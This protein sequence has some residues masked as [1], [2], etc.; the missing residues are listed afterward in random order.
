MK[1][2]LLLFLFLG[3]LFS[4]QS[5]NACCGDNGK[6]DL[7]EFLSTDLVAEVEV[8]SFTVDKEQQKF[9]SKTKIITNYKST[10][11]FS[12]EIIIVSKNNYLGVPL[13]P[14]K[15]FVWLNFDQQEGAYRLNQCNRILPSAYLLETTENDPHFLKYQKDRKEMV[16][17]LEGLRHK[18]EWVEEKTDSIETTGQLKNGMPVGIWKVIDRRNSVGYSLSYKN[19]LKDGT[20]YRYKLDQPKDKSITNY[21]EGRLEGIQYKLFSNGKIS[22]IATFKDGIANGLEINYQW[23]GEAVSYQGNKIN[24]VKE[25]LWEHFGLKG[26]LTKQIIYTLVPNQIP[27]PKLHLNNYP[28]REIQVFNSYGKLIKKTVYRFQEKVLEEVY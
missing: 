2:H 23:G 15:Y 13:V 28:R 18:T 4:H 3:I 5:L 25:G 14:G 11:F 19:G 20:H 12:K 8:V 26:R 27:E 21:K 17:Y 16:D 6:L 10:P 7:F 22:Q 1:K 9:V 24:G